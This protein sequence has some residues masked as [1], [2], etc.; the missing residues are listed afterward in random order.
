MIEGVAIN[1]HGDL[2]M[3]HNEYQ[4]IIHSEFIMSLSDDEKK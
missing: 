2:H 4:V 3:F 1:F